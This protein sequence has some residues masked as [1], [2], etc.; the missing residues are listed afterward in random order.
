MPL[1]IYSTKRAVAQRYELL[2]SG[3]TF[4]TSRATDL[5]NQVAVAVT[6]R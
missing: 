1:I 3:A 5:V 2:G 4:V 6:K